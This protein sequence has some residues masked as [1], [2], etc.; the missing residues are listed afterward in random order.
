MYREKIN[1]QWKIMFNLNIGCIWI[2]FR[3]VLQQVLLPSLTLTLVVFE[4][5]KSSPLATAAVSLTLTLV[6][7]ESGWIKLHFVNFIRLTLT[8]VVFESITHIKK[9]QRLPG[10]TLTLVVFELVYCNP[11]TSVRSAF[12]LNIGCI[13]IRVTFKSIF[14]FVK[15]NLNIGC[16]WMLFVETATWGLD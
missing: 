12:N 9:I 11:V 13:W 3:P 1:R 7:F 8:L 15:F 4:F 6:V 2:C 16:I 5:A 14:H 10:L